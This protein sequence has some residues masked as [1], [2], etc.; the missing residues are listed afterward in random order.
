LVEAEIKRFGALIG[1]AVAKIRPPRWIKQ[2]V[3]QDLWLFALER[4]RY[5]ENCSDNAI[6]FWMVQRG[7]SLIRK[8]KMCGITY[9][10]RDFQPDLH[11]ERRK[12]FSIFY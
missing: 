12:H 2:D 5:Y 10:P 11:W 4:V 7:R 8:E 6:V 3:E 1:Q 9:C